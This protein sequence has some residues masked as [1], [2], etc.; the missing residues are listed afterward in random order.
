MTKQYVYAEPDEVTAFMDT[1]GEVHAKREDA[2]SASIKADMRAALQ[3]FIG[4]KDERTTV[5]LAL[6]HLAENNLSLLQAFCEEAG[7]K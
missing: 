1:A 5:Y 7:W 4:D 3:V 6:K 2:I